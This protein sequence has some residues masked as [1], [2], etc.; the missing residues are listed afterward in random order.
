MGEVRAKATMMS[1]LVREAL[2]N[3]LNSKNPAVT[4]KH[5]RTAYELLSLFVDDMQTWPEEDKVDHVN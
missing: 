4:K 3:A 1:L 2:E 5:V